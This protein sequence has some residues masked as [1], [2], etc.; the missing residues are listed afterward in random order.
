MLSKLS[1]KNPLVRNATYYLAGVGSVLGLYVAKQVAE[2]GVT[3]YL[4]YIMVKSIQAIPGGSS[5]IAAEQAKVV[6]GLEKTQKK[7]RQGLGDQDTNT[8]LPNGSLSKDDVLAIMKAVSVSDVK[9]ADGRVWGYVYYQTKDKEHKS[10]LVEAYSMFANTNPL[11]PGMFPS[12]QKFESEVVAMTANLL[13]NK[14]RKTVC[15]NVTSGGTESILLSIK[16]T[17]EWVLSRRPD[18]KNPTLICSTTSHSS[19]N[20]ASEFFGFKVVRIPVRKEDYRADVEAIRKAIT[21]DTFMIYASAPCFPFGVIDPIPEIASLA[22]EHGIGLHVDCCLGGFVLPFM[23]MLGKELPYVYD[24]RLPGVTT[25]SADVHKY[26]LGPKGTS[27]VMFREPEIRKHMFFAYS[28]HTWL[29]CTPTVAG[30]RPGGLIAGAWA[31][32]MKNG[33]EGYKNVVSKLMT[34]TEEAK[35][36]INKIPELTVIGEPDMCGFAFTTTD[37]K[38]NIYHV[39]EVLRSKGWNMDRIVKPPALHLSITLNTDSKVIGEFLEDLKEAVTDVVA[40]PTKWGND[41]VKTYEAGD[42]MVDRTMLKNILVD[43]MDVVH[44]PY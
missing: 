29:Y 17:K 13:G 22:N 26:G 12:L 14:V 39:G 38:N 1:W 8:E 24:F 23:E 44:R 43:Y 11:T 4:E 15:G 21:K 31:A 27:V 5:I 16:A 34:Y 36:G 10:L 35:N 40:N 6:S 42:K 18:I 3:P 9:E 33:K 25:I 30:T 37:S 32:L 41:T 7:L 28:E 2:H 20:K 19:I